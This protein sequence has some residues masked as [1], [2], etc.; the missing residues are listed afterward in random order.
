MGGG[1]AEVNGYKKRTPVQA[2]F[3][4]GKM[5]SKLDIS[6]K[7]AILQVWKVN[8]TSEGRRTREKQAGGIAPGA[9]RPAGGAGGRAGRVAADDRL[10]GERAVQPVHPA[11]VQDRTVF[12]HADRGYLYL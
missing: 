5:E 8:F 3:S 2:F 6:E 1:N 11:G 9:R 10:A 12:R 7:R 4:F